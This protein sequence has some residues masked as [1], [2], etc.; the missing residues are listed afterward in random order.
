MM[1]YN[2]RINIEL[3]KIRTIG[4]SLA[5]QPGMARLISAIHDALQTIHQKLSDRVDPS[6]DDDEPLIKH[7]RD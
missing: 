6:E 4:E 2:D 7:F 3:L 5:D 1:D